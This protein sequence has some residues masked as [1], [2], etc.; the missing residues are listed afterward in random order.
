MK[1]WLNLRQFGRRT[2]TG[3]W[4]ETMKPW[5][6]LRQFGRRTLTAW[7]ETINNED[8]HMGKD[9]RTLTGAWIETLTDNASRTN[10]AVAPSRVRGLKHY[11]FENGKHCEKSHPHGCVD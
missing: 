11:H 9:C 5:L 7:I 4:I 3:A 8:S 6:N 2:L 10:W 1:P